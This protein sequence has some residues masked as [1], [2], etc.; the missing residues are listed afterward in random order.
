MFGLGG[1][2][3]SPL[4]KWIQLGGRQRDMRGRQGPL[5]VNRD[6]SRVV[7]LEMPPGHERGDVQRH[8]TIAFNFFEA[9]TRVTGGGR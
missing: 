8:V 3:L 9:I 6:G 5:D 4:V 2:R 1:C 7:A